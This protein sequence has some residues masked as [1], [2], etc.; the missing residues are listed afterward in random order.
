[1]VFGSDAAYAGSSAA[2]AAAA[3]WQQEQ[4]QQQL[5]Q[6]QQQVLLPPAPAAAPP[7]TP[8]QQMKASLLELLQGAAAEEGL[9]I[10]PK[11][12]RVERGFQVY[13][14]ANILFYIDKDII[15]AKNKSKA[16]WE[17]VAADVLL[18]LAAKHKK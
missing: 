2:A 17:P 10:R 13:I 3:M 16:Q 12:G 4:L 18:Q 9:S 6:H 15:F 7:P 5:Q 8:E 11:V 14:L 1:M